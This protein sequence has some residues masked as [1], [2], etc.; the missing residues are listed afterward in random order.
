MRGAERGAALP[1][2][3]LVAASSL[4]DPI[5]STAAKRLRGQHERTEQQFPVTSMEVATPSQMPHAS[6]TPEAQH[7]PSRSSI[8]RPGHAPSQQRPSAT[9]PD[10]QHTPAVSRTPV[11]QVCDERSQMAPVHP[12]VQAQAPSMQVPWDE[13]FWCWTWSSQ[14]SQRG[15][16][17]VVAGGLGAHLDGTSTVGTAVPFVNLH[18]AIIFT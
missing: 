13:Q 9:N 2:A 14:N 7:A 3:A 8:G 15:Q 11:V 6:T 12:A 4:H 5:G 17:M 16:R 1:A 10:M 18:K